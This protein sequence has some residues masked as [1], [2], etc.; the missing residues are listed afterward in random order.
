MIKQWLCWLKLKH[1][2]YTVIIILIFNQI[3]ITFIWLFSI[4]LSQSDILRFEFSELGVPAGIFNVTAP[5]I[6]GTEILVPR[7]ASA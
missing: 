6:V 3:G 4:I 2:R 7:D 1:N 5:F